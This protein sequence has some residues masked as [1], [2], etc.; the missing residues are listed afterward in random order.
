MITGAKKTFPIFF[1]VGG[2][3][4]VLDLA[5]IYIFTDLL[6]VWYLLSGVLSFIVTAT[7]NFLLNKKLTF[8][9]TAQNYRR[10]YT[11]FLVVAVFGLA[12]NTGLL[13]ICT[14]LFGIWYLASRV[15]SSLVAMV[16]NYLLN[17]KL[18]FRT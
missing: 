1:V 10:Q 18:V 2:F 11:Q 14:S 6:G 15:I 13:Y 12:I 7:I 3:C 8:R 16:W 4:A 5:L 9:N 17:S